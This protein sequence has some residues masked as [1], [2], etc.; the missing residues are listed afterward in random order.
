MTKL[1]AY[2]LLT[3]LAAL[4]PLPAVAQDEAG[5][6]VNVVIVYGDDAC[7]ASTADE[8]VVCP[9]LQEE[10]RYRI[11][12]LLRDNP[13]DTNKEAWTQKVRAYEYVGKEGT[14]SCSPTGG[15]GFTGCT[16]SLIDKAY[17]ERKGAPELQ[18]GKLIEAEREKR[19][20]TIDSESQDV[21]A[22]VK[23]IEARQAAERAAAGVPDAAT[24]DE[25]LPVPPQD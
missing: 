13:A 3:G 7:P 15:G 20:S 19:L 18:A 16:Q 11:P 2:W 10:E 4:A 24:T 23:E 21:E 5:D 14:M 9:R 25:P 8:I 17:A 6:R 1:K 22:R 12:P